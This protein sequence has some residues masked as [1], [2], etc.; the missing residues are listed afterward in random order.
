MMQETG[1][2]HHQI[3]LLLP[4]CMWALPITMYRVWSTLQL[5]GSIMG[6]NRKTWEEEVK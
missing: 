1:L 6:H 5:L 3:R 2:L 4:V